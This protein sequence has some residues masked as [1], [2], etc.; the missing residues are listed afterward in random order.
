[1]KKERR[2]EQKEKEMEIECGDG[3]SLGITPS[4]GVVV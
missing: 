4:P 1:M 3:R 2:N